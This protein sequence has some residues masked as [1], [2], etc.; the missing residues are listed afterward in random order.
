MINKKAK[1][2]LE[3]KRLSGLDENFFGYKT[4]DGKVYDNYLSNDTW[5]NFKKQMS[6][7]FRQSYSD[8]SGGELLPSKGRGGWYPPKMASIASSSRFA[9]LTFKDDPETTI[10]KIIPDIFSGGD[11]RFEDKISIPNV[12]G[13]PNL[14]ASYKVKGK[15]SVYFEA[16]CHE[17]FDTHY[18]I[19]RNAYFDNGAF[20]GNDC[21]S[22]C[23]PDYENNVKPHF[24]K[25]RETKLK[26]MDHESKELSTE[27]FDIGDE[28]L[29]LDIKQF[30]CH[31][32]GVAND[33]APKKE[34]IYL[35]F[36]PSSM[37]EFKEEYLILEKQFESFC[38]SDVIS[39]FCK[40]NHITLKLVYA[41]NDKMTDEF[42]PLIIYDFPN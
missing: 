15:L 27:I 31:L 29:Y 1:F 26:I 6:N 10:R 28:R 4:P 9:Y 41:T 30:V 3:I 42:M 23:I 24:K 20:F 11:F 5:D 25:D 18:P 14:D 19:W 39:S 7:R 40:R 16:K 21:K 37:I 38:K 2:D 33:E 8:G 32:L 12:S 36:K 35:Y 22:L 13:T 17:I 34:L